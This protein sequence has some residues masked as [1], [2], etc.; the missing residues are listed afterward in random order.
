MYLEIF[1]RHGHGIAIGL[2][3][4]VGDADCI[5]L[6]CDAESR[7]AKSLK[8]QD[9]TVLH[10]L[11]NLNTRKKSMFYSFTVQF[12]TT[13]LKNCEKVLRKTIRGRP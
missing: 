6:H 2:R 10:F 11:N 8:K 7:D 3:H 4:I 13:T 9:K 12:K 5:R 1:K